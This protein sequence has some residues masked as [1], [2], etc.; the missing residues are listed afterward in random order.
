MKY[1]GLIMILLI[2]GTVIL[3]FFLPKEGFWQGEVASV[4]AEAPDFELQDTDGNN[5]KLSDLRGKVIFLNFWA[6]WC[7]VCRGEIPSKERLYKKMQGKPFQMLSVIFRDK[8]Q[9]VI[10]Y[11]RKNNLA[12]PA[13]ID[14]D[15]E[16]AIAYGITGVP[17]TFVIDKDGIIREK[18]V[19]GREWDSPEALSLI[20][21]W[22]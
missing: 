3:L 19:G 17:E 8:P 13:L 5:W 20:E 12:V 22:L 10:A 21:K 14:T 7:R 15:Y 6:T 2:I 18:V 11:K 9:K 4:S 16:V 1:K